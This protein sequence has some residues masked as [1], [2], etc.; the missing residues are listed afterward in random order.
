[1]YSSYILVVL[2]KIL[3]LLSIPKH[4]LQKLAELASIYHNKL[5]EELIAFSKIFKDLVGNVCDRTTYIYF[6]EN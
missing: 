1:M 5:V 3:Y 2:K 4:G 6:K